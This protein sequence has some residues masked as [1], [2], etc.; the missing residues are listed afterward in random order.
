MKKRL[1]IGSI[2]VLL[3][4]LVA[5]VSYILGSKNNQQKALENSDPLGLFT[6]ETQEAQKTAQAV[7]DDITYYDYNALYNLV[8][9][10]GRKSITEEEFVKN[11]TQ[12]LYS[13]NDPE[14]TCKVDEVS[15]NGNN[16]RVRLT[17]SA[18]NQTPEE[19]RRTLYMQ[20][21]DKHWYMNTDL[22]TDIMP[23]VS[24]SI[25]ISASAKVPFYNT[26]TDTPIP[27]ANSS[28]HTVLT[29]SG[30]N[31]DSSTNVFTIKGSEWK[32]DYTTSNSTGAF[33][34]NPKR[35]GDNIYAGDMIFVSGSASNSKIE[36]IPPG[37]YYLDI[38]SVGQSYTLTVEDYY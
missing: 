25:T 14:I 35:E 6:N 22:A 8:I 24:P 15:V 5:S 16:A 13:A 20:Y 12:Q 10:A 28:W 1:V 26:T 30:N 18:K 32:I 29:T 19:V 11:Y 7:C 21:I 17:I 38:N 23:S 33:S 27:Q 4:L 36:H 3:I 37:Q 2:G 34:V 31:G 9:P